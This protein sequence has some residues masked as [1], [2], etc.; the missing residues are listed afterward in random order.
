MEHI[1]TIEEN[2]SR[3]DRVVKN[4]C[5]DLGYVFLQKIFRTNR[6][7]INGK[8]ARAGDRVQVGDAIEIYAPLAVTTGESGITS[9]YSTNA[10]LLTQLQEM[11]IFEDDGM[12]AIN[13][14]NHLAVQMGSR[15]SICVET[16]INAYG[17]GQCR[18]VH[19]LDKDTSGILLIAKT[20]LMARR[21]TQL[22]RENKI[23]KTYLAVVDGVVRKPGT[24]DVFLGK[25]F[26]GNEE[27]MCI[28]PDG[29]NP[30]AR[31]STTH[32]KPL[33]TTGKYTL[34][35]LK[36]ITGRKHQ[37]RLHCSD[38]LRA[39]IVGDVK[40][41]WKTKTELE[42]ERIGMTTMNFAGGFLFLHAHKLIIEDM[43]IRII[44]PP[45]PHMS[46]AITFF[47]QKKH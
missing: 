44:A 21:L 16:F 36:P 46:S 24:I 47:H 45:P 15:V 14:P 40:Y 25:S 3:A 37:L 20:K 10:Q 29:Q 43:G 23:H 9:C 34:L 5:G 22:F 11:I 17:H 33:C 4:I 42:L 32:Y 1:V 38:M 28:V 35:E 7:K 19:R 27:K 12:L 18:L 6:V 26:F 39:P 2:N 31:R 41:G 30:D 13:K 8:K